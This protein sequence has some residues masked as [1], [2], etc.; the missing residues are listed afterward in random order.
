[1]GAYTYGISLR[2][3]Q[4]V[5]GNRYK[6]KKLMPCRLVKVGRNR[7]AVNA[8]GAVGLEI[9]VIAIDVV[10][11]AGLGINVIALDAARAAGGNR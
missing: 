11:V 10:R 7:I 1:V 9:N 5:G 6:R 8:V 4:G 2:C 3:C